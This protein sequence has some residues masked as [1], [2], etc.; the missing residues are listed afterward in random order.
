MVA[1]VRNNNPFTVVILFIYALVVNYS[2]LFEPQLP[3]LVEGAFLY[4]IIVN[5]FAIIFFKSAFAFTFMSVTM[6]VLQGIYLNTIA[7]NNRIYNK[8][9]YTVTFVYISLCS[10]YVPFV[11]FS[12]LLLANWAVIFIISTF[13]HLPHATKPRKIVYNTGFVVGVAALIHFP[14]ILMALLVMIALATLRP[15][16]MG[17]WMVAI[18]GILT[19]IYFAA[20]MLFLFDRLPWMQGWVSMG[21]NLPRSMASPVYF[22]GMLTGTIM[23]FVMGVYVLQS[24]V[25]RL[26]VYT[27]RGW[28]AIHIGLFISVLVA[29]FTSFDVKAAWLIIMPMLSLVVTNIYYHKKNK[30][31]SNFAFYF[32]LALVIFCKMT[33]V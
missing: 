23:L 6:V 22:I 27:R 15:L 12:Q 17:E 11:H 18:L 21:I 3:E 1:L 10:L 30:A 9:S 33:G 5:F 14:F 32:M 28:T 31:F 24:V 29:V 16:N 20:G 25:T 4:N 7:N 13:F 8:P 26:N 19:P 2:A